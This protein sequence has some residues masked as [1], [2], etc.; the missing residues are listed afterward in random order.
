MAHNLTKRQWFN[1][2]RRIALYQIKTDIPFIKNHSMN[3]KNEN[4]K[5]AEKDFS[6]GVTPLESFNKI[7]KLRED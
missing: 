1:Q 2:I 5:L 4:Y 6:M 7:K 3:N